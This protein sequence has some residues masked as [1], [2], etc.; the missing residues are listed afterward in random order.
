MEVPAN[1]AQWGTGARRN[2][3]HGS[4]QSCKLISEQAPAGGGSVSAVC[5]LSGE[6]PKNIVNYAPRFLR[7]PFFLCLRAV[8]DAVLDSGEQFDHYVSRD[9]RRD[10]DSLIV[11]SLYDIN[12]IVSINRSAE[13]GSPAPQAVRASK[14]ERFPMLISTLPRWSTN[15]QRLLC[16][17][18][19]SFV[20]RQR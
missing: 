19:V 3:S 11:I 7:Q 17:L 12:G 1:P 6:P 20:G 18:Y 4:F 5:R 15:R 10:S 13:R 16:R 8:S 2:A 9:D 14:I